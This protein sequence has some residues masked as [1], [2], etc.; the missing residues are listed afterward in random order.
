MAAEPAGAVERI[1]GGGL[2]WHGMIPRRLWKPES[3]SRRGGD[4]P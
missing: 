2:E 4:R 3:A 1:A